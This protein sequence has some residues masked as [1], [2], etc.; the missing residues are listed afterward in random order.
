MKI[1]KIKKEA[2]KLKDWRLKNIALSSLKG[3]KTWSNIDHHNSKSNMK[4]LTCNFFRNG[5]FIK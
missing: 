5:K 1:R 2:K 3:I 4:I